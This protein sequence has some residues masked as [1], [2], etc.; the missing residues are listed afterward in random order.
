MVLFPQF[1]SMHAP[2][3]SLDIDDGLGVCHVVLLSAHCALLVHNHQIVC[4]D[5]AA[6][7]EVVQAV[8]FRK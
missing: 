6:L 3:H 5:Y 7:Q 2:E 4:V 1:G 8:V